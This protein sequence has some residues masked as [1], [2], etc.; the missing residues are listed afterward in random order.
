MTAKPG[1][2]LQDDVI[3]LRA[4][5][6]A[7]TE[8]YLAFRNDLGATGDLIGYIRGVPRHKVAE[9]IA[10]VDNRAG[11][12][13]TTVDLSDSRPVGYV[14][15]SDID[16]VSGT[17]RIGLAVFSP[18]DR[19][20]G[21]GR[22]IMD[23]MLGYCREWLNI[24]KVSLVVLADNKAAVALYEKCGF[25]VEGTLKD[26]YFLDGRYRSALIMARFLR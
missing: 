6:P 13:L 10:T 16:A 23:L 5:E 9:W 14:N 25:A 3:G 18:A 2:L 21:Y 20:K 17:C 12:T 8:A 7:D 15:V 22:R 26:E 24:R 19:G 11:V 4:P 1:Y